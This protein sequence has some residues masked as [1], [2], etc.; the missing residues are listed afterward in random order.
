MENETDSLVLT[1]EETFNILLSIKDLP[2]IPKIMLEVQALLRS[3]SHNTV[4]LSSIVGKDH[5]LTTKILMVANS[6]LYGL[7]RKVSS[8]E[9][10][11]MLLGVNEV[12]NIVTA[13]SLAETIKVDNVKGLNF[14]EFWKH[15]MLVGTAAKDIA[16]RL[17]FFDLSGDAF[18][19][20]MLHDLGIQLTARYFPK[21]YSKI[22][23]SVAKDGLNFKDAEEKYLGLTHQEIGGFIS[24]RWNL[25]PHLINSLM[26][27]HNPYG[28]MDSPVVPYIVHVADCMTQKFKIA[29][30]HWDEGLEFDKSVVNVL[31]FENEEK[32]IDFVEDYKVRFEETANSIVF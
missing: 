19:G 8:L 32:F 31:K 18:V 27:H 5:G 10:A 2:S 20:G 11:I 7:Q 25:P 30:V 23:E 21:Q 24:R 1:G 12:S 26:F 6:P 16:K 3:E 4:K 22:V 15:S 13:L 14:M 28:A 29:D 9:F 17:G